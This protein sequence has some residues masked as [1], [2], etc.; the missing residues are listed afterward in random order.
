M[1]HYTAENY[2]PSTSVGFALTRAR[3]TLLG[4]MDAALRDLDISSQQMGI[5]L[6]L[7]RNLASTPFELSKLL[8]I[9][10]GLMTR[11]LDKLEHQDLLVRIRSVDDRRMV[12]LQ[13]TKHG[14]HVAGEIPKR[15]PNVLNARLKEFTAA[16]FHEFHRLLSKFIGA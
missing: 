1:K 4:E 6:A 2:D 13:L 9:D 3:N 16:E 10:S 8:D 11:M 14:K 15:A 12:N 7:A 5:I